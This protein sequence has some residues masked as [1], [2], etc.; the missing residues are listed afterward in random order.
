M[1]TKNGFLT[2]EPNDSKLMQLIA[3][4]MRKKGRMIPTTEAEVNAMPKSKSDQEALPDMLA[5]PM[6]MLNRGYMKPSVDSIKVNEPE[7]FGIAARN[8]NGLSKET[9]EKINRLLDE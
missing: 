3:H 9:I 8:G 4:A 2:N 1:E 6:A 5:D 7:A